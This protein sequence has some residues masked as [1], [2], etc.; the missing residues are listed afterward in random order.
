MTQDILD[1]E[2]EKKSQTSSTDISLSSHNI[3]ASSFLSWQGFT[4]V[5]LTAVKQKYSI[6]KQRNILPVIFG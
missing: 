2:K 6:W 4:D 1:M 3:S 5:F